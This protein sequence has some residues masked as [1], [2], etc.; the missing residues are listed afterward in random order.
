[1]KKPRRK[2]EAAAAPKKGRLISQGNGIA[3]AMP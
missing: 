1:M 3:Q 2:A